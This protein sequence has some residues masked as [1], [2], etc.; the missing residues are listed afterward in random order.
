MI[1]TKTG[2]CPVFLFAFVSDKTISAKK[3][4]GAFF[5]DRE[6][7]HTA[8]SHKRKHLRTD[9]VISDISDADIALQ[10]YVIRCCLCRSGVSLCA[11]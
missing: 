3:A 10:L 11:S 2:Q 9:P 4:F 7:D 1:T 8:R 6:Q 5:A